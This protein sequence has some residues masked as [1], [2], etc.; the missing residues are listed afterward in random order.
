MFAYV[1][2]FARAQKETTYR[3]QPAWYIQENIAVS[4]GFFDCLRVSYDL[5]DTQ[6]DFVPLVSFKKIL[7][8]LLD[9]LIVCV[10]HMIYVMHKKTLYRSYPVRDIQGRESIDDSFY[11]FSVYLL[12]S[13]GL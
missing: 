7:L 3:L 1:I 8:F 5:R 4:F 2:Y 6:E 10:C 13:F 11:T 12:L 9:F